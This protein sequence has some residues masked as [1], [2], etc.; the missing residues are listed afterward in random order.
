MLMQCCMS[1]NAENGVVCA[2]S[3]FTGWWIVKVVFFPFAKVLWWQKFKNFSMFKNC[4]G[5][6][7][8]SHHRKKGHQIRIHHTIFIK[9]CIY[10]WHKCCMVN[11]DAFPNNRHNVEFFGVCVFFSFVSFVFSFFSK[12]TFKLTFSSFVNEKENFI[13]RQNTARYSVW[14]VE[15]E[16]NMK[17]KMRKT[18]RTVKKID[19]I[20]QVHGIWRRK[21]FNNN[22][23]DYREWRRL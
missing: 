20:I 3:M 4:I 7:W 5:K 21:S 13:E 14:A 1:W 17:M 2:F 19:K 22:A 6:A 15:N 18:N 23:M 16:S 9:W 12:Y 11:C 10:C 8:Q